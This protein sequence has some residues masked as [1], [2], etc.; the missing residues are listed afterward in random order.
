MSWLHTQ[1]RLNLEVP[2]SSVGFL[3]PN[4]TSLTQPIDHGV[5]R[6]FKALYMRSTMEGLISS[7]DEDNEGCCQAEGVLSGIFGLWDSK[8]S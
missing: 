5:T 1:G 3:P 2:E 6:A 8:G 7:I 4:T